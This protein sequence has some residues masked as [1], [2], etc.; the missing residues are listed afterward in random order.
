[1]ECAVLFISN[2]SFC[3]FSFQIRSDWGN[4]GR[5]MRAYE[6]I[7]EFDCVSCIHFA[8]VD[9]EKYIGPNGYFS[10]PDSRPLIK[11]MRC[12]FQSAGK[13]RR[14]TYRRSGTVSAMLCLGSASC[15]H[16]PV[17]FLRYLNGTRQIR[18]ASRDAWWSGVT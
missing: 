18:T 3:L 14:I 9:L 7:V 6:D 1:M 15:L 11:N 10:Q 4:T 16:E 8:A 12:E 17:Y 13:F 5:P 2:I